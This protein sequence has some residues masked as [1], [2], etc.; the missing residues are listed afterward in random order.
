MLSGIH[1]FIVQNIS[2]IIS[3]KVPFNYNDN[4]LTPEERRKY[5]LATK[6]RY[7]ANKYR[8]D[9]QKGFDFFM[10]NRMNHSGVIKGGA[11]GGLKQDGKYNIDA[12]FNKKTLIKQIEAIS[13]QADHIT[14]TNMEAGYFIN[15]YVY[16]I[17]DDIENSF[18]FLDPPYFVQGKALYSL[19]ATDSI[20]QLIAKNLQANSAKIKWILTYDKA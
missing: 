10:L 19:F 9:K 13:E 15:N 2:L 8:S 7:Q 4:P 12:R 5:W 6:K 11:I 14:V 18:M 16:Q 3:K 17:L 20:H 1:W